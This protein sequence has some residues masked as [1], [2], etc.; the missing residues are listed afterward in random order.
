MKSR[1]DKNHENK[2][3]HLNSI[4]YNWQIMP[5]LIIDIKSFQALS[6]TLL[7]K[8]SSEIINQHSVLSDLLAEY[9][10]HHPLMRWKT[11]K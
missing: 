11:K 7:K 5:S 8:P 4:S 1:F 9:A 10:M 2:N 3:N 6:G